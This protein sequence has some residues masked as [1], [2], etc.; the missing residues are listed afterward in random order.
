MLRERPG[1]LQHQLLRARL[2]GPGHVHKRGDLF[3]EV[4][5][6]FRVGVREGDADLQPVSGRVATDPAREGAS[7]GRN[8]PLE[9]QS[10]RGV[11]PEAAARFIRR[12]MTARTV[13]N[14]TVESNR[15]QASFCHY[16][17]FGFAS[18]PQLTNQLAFRQAMRKL[19]SALAPSTGP[20]LGWSRMRARSILR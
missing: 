4:Q 8:F 10:S 1:G 19:W 15:G 2:H 7:A 13:R 17:Q 11:R 5:R 3:V 12:L 18:A 16:L 9:S 6:G 14:Y 20:S